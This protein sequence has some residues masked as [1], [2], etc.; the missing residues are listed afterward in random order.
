MGSIAVR[1][2]VAIVGGK[3]SIASTSLTPIA[4]NFSKT[5]ESVTSPVNPNNLGGV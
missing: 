5:T 1:V 4:N 3:V 2:L